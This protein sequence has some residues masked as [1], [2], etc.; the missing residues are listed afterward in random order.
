M[1]I[2]KASHE[3]YKTIYDIAVQTWDVAYKSIL[4]EAQLEYMMNMMYS[5]K[6]FTEQLSINGHHFLIASI[7]GK[8]LGFAS[9]ELNYR[10]ETTKIHKLYVLPQTQGT[11]MG[12]ALIKAVEN[13]AKTNTNDKITLNVNRNNKAVHFYLKNGFENVG[14]EDVAI[15][16][17]YLMEDY[18]MLKQL[19]Y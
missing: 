3:D 10:Y 12:Q 14:E 7:D 13:A 6:A 19:S 17:G 16:N 9:Y 11:G 5:E 1:E 15:G 4:S 8:E 2:R 18:I